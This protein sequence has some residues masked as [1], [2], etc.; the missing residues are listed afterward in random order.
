MAD[1]RA[2]SGG[3]AAEAAGTA[4]SRANDERLLNDLLELL[5]HLEQ[6]RAQLIEKPA[7]KSDPAALS[8]VAALVNTV[9]EFVTARTNDPT[10]LPSRVLASVADT[11]PYTQ[12]FG[13]EQERITVVTAVAALSEW[14]G[15]P[16]D[17]GKL[18]RDLC[19]AAIDVLAVYC[20]A[21]AG[22]FKVERD[23]EEWRTMSD[24]FVADLRNTFLQAR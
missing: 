11:L 12:L 8:S 6:H 23:R 7:A 4:T 18:V 15:A 16:R 22:L 5:S 14:K 17:R 21:I 9:V 1:I 10:L 24:L 2:F 20:Q 3:A 13:E 19:E